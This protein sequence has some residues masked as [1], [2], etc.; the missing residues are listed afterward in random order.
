MAFYFICHLHFKFRMLRSELMFKLALFPRFIIGA[1]LFWLSLGLSPVLAAEQSIISANW[2]GY[3]ADKGQYTSISASWTVPRVAVN[4]NQEM[5]ADAVWVGVGG[6]NQHKD[7]IQVGTQTIVQNGLPQYRFWYELLPAGAVTLPYTLQPGDSVT[8]T[9]NEVSNDLWQILFINNTTHQT[10]NKYVQY[11]S[12][13]SSAEWIVEMPANYSDRQMITLDDFGTVQ[14]E[15]ASTINNGEIETI[16]K[17]AAILINMADNQLALATTSILTP[18][19]NGF[20]IS[21]F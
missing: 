13:H 20:S 15:D 4:Q 3:I 2:A 7:L 19:G 16:A 10:F 6:F 12:S 1:S 14:F 5:A 9:L 8:V 21:R 17:A 11:S 18:A